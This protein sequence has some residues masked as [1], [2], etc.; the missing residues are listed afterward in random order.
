MDPF[1]V[2]V[3]RVGAQYKKL[4]EEDHKRMQGKQVEHAMAF[5]FD[6]RHEQKQQNGDLVAFV[7]TGGKHKDAVHGNKRT[8]PNAFIRGGNEHHNQPDADKHKQK[9]A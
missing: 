4:V 8:Q 5:V 3:E 7:H 2:P 6:A 1:G 9:H